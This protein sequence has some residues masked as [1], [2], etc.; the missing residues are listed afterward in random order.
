M[1][2]RRVFFVSAGGQKRGPNFCCAGI[3]SANRTA[4]NGRY[5]EFIDHCG[6]VPPNAEFGRGCP[7][8][9]KDVDGC[10]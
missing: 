6:A 5:R 9:P 2:S 1:I 4:T 10:L 7:I 3:C 8:A